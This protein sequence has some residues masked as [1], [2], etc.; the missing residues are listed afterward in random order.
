MLYDPIHKNNWVMLGFS[1]VM[2]PSV[3]VRMQM[4]LMCSGDLS[5]LGYQVGGKWQG[6]RCTEYVM[7]VATLLT[8]V[9]WSR[10]L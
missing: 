10:S 5:A 7:T 1:L 4:D 2:G 8:L 9:F 6:K 3:V